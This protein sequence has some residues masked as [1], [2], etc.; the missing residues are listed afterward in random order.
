MIRTYAYDDA[1]QLTEHFNSSEFRCK[2]DNQHS[3]N[4]D[5]KIDDDLVEGLEALF[6]KIPELFGIEVSKIILTSGYRCPTHDIEV[7]GYG[8]G[9][10]VDGYAADF[11][12]YD[13]DEN[14]VSSKMVCCAAQEIGFNGIANITDAYIYTHC[15]TKGRRWYGNEVYSNSTVT[16]DFWSYYGLS[17]KTDTKEA[18]V[19][20]LKGIDVS[21]WQGDID[22]G[23]AAPET[24]FV[25]LRAGYG[26]E[27]SQVDDKF[28]RNYTG[29]K[30][31][32]TPVGAY[33]YCYAVSAEEAKQEAKV[34]LKY[35]KGKQFELPIFYD[36]LED[37]H[38]PK[39]RAAG[40]VSRLINE[41]VTAFC[42]VLEDNGYFVGLYCSTAGYN[43]LNDANKQRYVQWVADWRS[44]C[45][46]SGDKVLWQYSA[47]GS[48]S[49]ISG[50]VDKDY[51]YT[52][53]AIIKEK[54]FNG[55]D[56]SDYTD[57][58]KTPDKTPKP[59]AVQPAKVVNPT[60]QEATDVFEQ[61]LKEVQEINKKLDNK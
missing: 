13:K 51:A 56:S 58:S 12:V 39:L 35:L 4:H 46:Y 25:V 21:S 19:V 18:E 31:K 38:L 42:S 20:K 53:F 23:K 15:D 55:W 45:G 32:G 7:G 9:P 1:I 16:D 22:F 47:K 6:T 61:I 54:G 17:R 50:D 30:K 36:I 2:S 40:D 59:A 14:P 33:W 44:N 5:Y 24:D 37:D 27:F 8:S 29:F 11:I 28:E 48:I 43:Y 41:V 26:K 52:D 10:H 49:G 3:G 34:C 57:D 60:P